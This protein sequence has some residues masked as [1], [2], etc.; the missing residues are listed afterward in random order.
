MTE[1]SPEIVMR[2]TTPD[3][4]EGFEFAVKCIYDLTHNREDYTL[5]KLNELLHSMTVLM[6]HGFWWPDIKQ[7][8]MC[9]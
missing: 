5:D 7:V 3:F 1:N 6:A 2:E 9:G 8:I 4:R